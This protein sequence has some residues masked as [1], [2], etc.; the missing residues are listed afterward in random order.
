MNGF[1]PSRAITV[2]AWTSSDSAVD[3]SVPQ[4]EDAFFEL[5]GQAIYYKLYHPAYHAVINLWSPMEVYIVIVDGAITLEG[6]GIIFGTDRFSGT[7]ELID[8]VI[9]PT[10]LGAVPSFTAGAITFDGEQ[11]SATFSENLTLL[12]QL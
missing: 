8:N 5:L 2:P 6:F 7:F 4:T 3:T 12:F 1:I 10:W 11:I 9:E